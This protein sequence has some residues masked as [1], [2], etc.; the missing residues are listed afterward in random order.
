MMFLCV[1]IGNAT[2]TASSIWGP[3]AAQVSAA[4]VASVTESAVAALVVSQH[5]YDDEDD[6][7]DDF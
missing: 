2:I 4:G 3:A 1:V 7:D 5:H 6:D